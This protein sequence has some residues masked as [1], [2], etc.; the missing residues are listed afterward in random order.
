MQGIE[1]TIEELVNLRHQFSNTPFGH[2]HI[3]TPSSGHRL[4]KIKG[5]GIDFDEVREYQFGDDIRSIDWKTS[6]RLQ[7]TYS[8]TYKEER[9]RPVYILVDFNPNMF[10]GTKQAL[11]SVI[12]ARL[13]TLISYFAVAHQDKVGGIIYGN[14]HFEIKPKANKLGIQSL[15]KALVFVHNQSVANPQFVSG[16]KNGLMRIRRSI[17]PG[18]LL[19]VLSDFSTLKEEEKSLI[20]R[21]GKHND[22]VLT[23]IYDVLERYAP[24][25]GK[26]NISN[27][28][29]QK[30]LN[31]Q[32]KRKITQ[33]ETIWQNK[34]N[35]L[36]LFC[37]QNRQS[38]LV[39]NSAD[40]LMQVLLDSLRIFKK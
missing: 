21:I 35:D 18:S 36:A 33:Y 37:E 30:I 26:Y 15:I 7:K 16:L 25:S 11:K 14:S 9:E 27:G 24:H 39:I 34:Y 17:K 1:V 40:N 31:T 32:T 2:K 19:F 10:F 28:H 12:T 22:I 6:A 8:K 13:A 38:L 3:R 23:F 4:S 5:H 29:I 20:S